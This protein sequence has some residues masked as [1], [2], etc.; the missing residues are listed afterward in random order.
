MEIPQGLDASAFLQESFSQG[1]G[2]LRRDTG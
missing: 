1:T 2:Y